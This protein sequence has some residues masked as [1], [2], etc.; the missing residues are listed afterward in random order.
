MCA[1]LAVMLGP[2]TIG[3]SCYLVYIKGKARVLA[4]KGLEEVTSGFA[5]S[6]MSL[7]ALVG[8]Y[9]VQRR[10]LAPLFDEGGALSLN[11]KAG[12]DSLG[13]PLKITTW[14]HFYRA[15]GPPVFART[16]FLFASFYVAGGV[17]AWVASRDV[18]PPKAP[19]KQAA[20]VAR[21]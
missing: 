12:T 19:P 20:K 11:W 13:E 10:A 5:A 6:S 7:A 14:R 8:T 4:R 18:E 17:H 16:A 3:Y 2:P 15:A 1:G 21:R 9:M